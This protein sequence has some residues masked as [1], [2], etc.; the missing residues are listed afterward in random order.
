[1][2]VS[3]F[4]LQGVSL[5]FALQGHFLLHR[6]AVRCVGLLLLYMCFSTGAIAVY[7]K[8]KSFSTDAT[9]V[10]Q[11]ILKYQNGYE[12]CPASPEGI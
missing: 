4:A 8:V 11:R 10:F 12:T 3:I 2:S 6:S 5:A 7:W 1:M 9:A